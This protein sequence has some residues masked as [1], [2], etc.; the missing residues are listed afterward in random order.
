VCVCV[1]LCFCLLLESPGISDVTLFC[2]SQKL[3]PTPKS[4]TVHTSRESSAD[5][6]SSRST[7]FVN[8]RAV[9]SP[10]T[11]VHKLTAALTLTILPVTYRHPRIFYNY[12]RNLGF[13][14]LSSTT[15][16]CRRVSMRYRGCRRER[17]LVFHLGR[18]RPQIP[19][20]AS[21]D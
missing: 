17:E 8:L 6:K 19:V 2:C 10:V 7:M 15:S 4:E 18:G 11:G 20:G 5:R 21:G 16:P 3:D 1:C 9:T 12:R 13:I 14:S